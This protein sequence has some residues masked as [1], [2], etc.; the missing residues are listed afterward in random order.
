MRQKLFLIVAAVLVI[1]VISWSGFSQRSQTSKNS[2]EYLVIS[3]PGL[4]P[5]GKRTLNE[6][7]AQGWDLVGVSDSVFDHGDQTGTRLFFKRSK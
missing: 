1:G 4:S 6:L 7:G 3:D 5:E 2:W